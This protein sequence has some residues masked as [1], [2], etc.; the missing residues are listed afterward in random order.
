M[1]NMVNCFMTKKDDPLI[2]PKPP[3]PKEYTIVDK[4]FE[5]NECIICLEEM[6][7]GEKI[8]ILECGHIYHYNCI[9]DWFKRVKECPICFK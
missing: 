5:N 8:K 9:N 6:I 1:F 7:K 2:P 4:E 3:K